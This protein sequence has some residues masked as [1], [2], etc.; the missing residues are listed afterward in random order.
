MGIKKNGNISWLQISDLHIFKSCATKAFHRDLKSYFEG[1]LDFMLVTGNLHQYEKPSPTSG[2]GNYRETISELE[3]IMSSV[4][5]AEKKD[6]F[7]VPGN[8]DVISFRGKNA[9]ISEIDTAASNNPDCYRNPKK[10]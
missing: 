5:L 6:I 3:T 8:H 9:L 4:G 10:H 1:K 2:I 7:M